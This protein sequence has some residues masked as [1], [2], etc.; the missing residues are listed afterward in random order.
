M[1][2][3]RVEGERVVDEAE[4][5]GSQGRLLMAVLACTPAP[6]GRRDL[7]EILWDGHPP[8]SFESS[9]RPVLSKVRSAVEVAG[10]SRRLVASG[11]GTVELRRGA[12]IWVD[13]EQAV[14]RLDAAGGALRRG[15]HRR[16]W[17]DAAV[18][19]SILGRPFLPGIDHEWAIAHRRS[20]A[21]MHVRAYEVICD[22]WLELGDPEQAVAAATRLVA[23]D[24]YLESS[25]ERLMRA[26]LTAGNPARAVRAFSDLED[27]LRDDLGLSPSTAVQGVYEEA[28]AASS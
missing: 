9:L 25:S 3:M 7:A 23:M 17:V 11:A 22:V 5:P 27:R 26:H 1:G 10:G 8:S 14:T 19:S 28:L 24:P 18:A 21:R 15:D 4:L 13:M 16:A 2:R 6:I 20:L 12:D